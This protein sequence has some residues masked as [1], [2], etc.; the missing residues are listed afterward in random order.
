MSFSDSKFTE[1]KN[2]TISAS[3]KTGVW[4]DTRTSLG[5][6]ARA[7][8]LYSTTPRIISES[9]SNRTAASEVVK[10]FEQSLENLGPSTR[11]VYVAGARSALRAANLE[12][13]Q[14]P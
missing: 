10:D 2:A 4:E 13:W 12:L 14:R 9:K 7:A 1:S 5:G 11:R 6:L 3:S 8:G